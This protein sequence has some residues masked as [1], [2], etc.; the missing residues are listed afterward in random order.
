METT[1]MNSSI[2]VVIVLIALLIGCGVCFYFMFRTLNKLNEENKR[3]TKAV[4]NQKEIISA[5]TKAERESKE[6]KEKL[7]KGSND[8][9]LSATLDIL[10]DI[11]MCR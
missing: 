2:W 10:Q 8:E 11:E 3:L 9:R 7:G 5:F 6:Q 1:K 4:K